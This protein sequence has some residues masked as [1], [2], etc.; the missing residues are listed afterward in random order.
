MLQRGGARVVVNLSSEPWDVPGGDV[1]IAST[2]PGR[3]GDRLVVAPD[4]AVV[5]GE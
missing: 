1:W 3:E 4:S 5:I 2:D